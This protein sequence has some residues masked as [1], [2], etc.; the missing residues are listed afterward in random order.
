MKAR[1]YPWLLAAAALSVFAGYFLF[2]F[3]N[4][5]VTTASKPFPSILP[6]MAWTSSEAFVFFVIAV[7]G[8]AAICGGMI[9]TVAALFFGHMSTEENLAVAKGPVL[10]M[11]QAA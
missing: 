5:A 9:A 11:K 10:A 7:R 2:Y 8:F 3:S 6:S 4:L 1:V